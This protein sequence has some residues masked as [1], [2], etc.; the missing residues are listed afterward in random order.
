MPK[1][2]RPREREQAGSWV[3]VIAVFQ[4]LSPA[5]VD[6]HMRVTVLRCTLPQW[7]NLKL[8]KGDHPLLADCTRS[9]VKS[10]SLAV[11]KLNLLQPAWTQSCKSHTMGAVGR[12]VGV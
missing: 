7:S 3:S 8:I 11:C 4:E 1:T 9:R 12:G 5:E 6:G 2:T 10:G